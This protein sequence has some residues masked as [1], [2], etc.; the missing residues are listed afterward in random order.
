MPSS[1]RRASRPHH[2]RQVTRHHASHSNRLLTHRHRL[3]ALFL[4]VR[5]CSTGC[6]RG[7][8][9]GSNGGST[10][11]AAAVESAVAATGSAAAAA[12]SPAA[13]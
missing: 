13:A 3:S 5:R 9:G 4:P 12:A 10:V 6:S 7:S 8:S 1:S 11:A 2:L